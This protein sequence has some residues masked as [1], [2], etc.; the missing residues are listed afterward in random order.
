MSAWVLAFGDEEKIGIGLRPDVE[1]FGF[2]KQARDGD[3]LDF[4]RGYK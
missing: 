4:S 2:C 1:R 3:F